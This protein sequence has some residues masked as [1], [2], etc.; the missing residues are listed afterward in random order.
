MKL[1]AG[2]DCGGSSTRCMIVRED[3]SI[4]GEGKGGASNYLFLGK[5]AAGRA[6]QD[7]VRGAFAAA[8]EPE[9]EIAGAF[10]AS[11]A[12]EVFEGASHEPFFK[13]VTGCQTL[14][15]DSDILPVWY[16]GGE[17]GNRLAPAIAMIAGTGAVTYLLFEDHFIK[18]DGWGPHLGDDG[19]GYRIG[20]RAL[21]ETAKMADGRIKTDPEFYEAVM[22]FYHVPLERPRRLLPAVNKEDFRSI[23][24]SVTRV[25]EGLCLAG[26]ETACTIYEEAAEELE[27]SV[28]AVLSR[29]EGAYP[30][31]LAGGN[32][33]EGAPLSEMVM[34]RLEGNDRITR[35]M[36]PKVPAVRSAASM[37]LLAAGYADAAERL[38]EQ[39]G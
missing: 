39:E 26:N 36:I 31:Y 28:N 8:G 23:A 5:D 30:L 11:A 3:G 1:Y 38:M 10:V 22:N 7:A 25:L 20:L 13:E 34:R 9:R 14:S 37:A 24:A 19:S 33:R 18:G 35:I 12:V 32:L 15:C 29:S 17:K 27:L 16:A 4:L 21:Q 2:F 6:L